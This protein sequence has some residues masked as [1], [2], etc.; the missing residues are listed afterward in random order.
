M[1]R[2]TDSQRDEPPTDESSRRT[3]LKAGS[4]TLVGGAFAFGG[5]SAVGAQD[6]G[7]G[8][9]VESQASEGVMYPEHF[10][11]NA[12]FTITSPPID[13][14]PQGAEGFL[15]SIFTDYNMRT[16]RYVRPNTQ[17]IPLFVQEEADVG[18]YSER[19]GFAVDNDFVRN[20]NVVLDGTPIQQVNAQRLT[21]VRPTIFALGRN[22]EP[23]QDSDQLVSVRFSPIPQQA[24]Q[25]V[26]DQYRQQIFGGSTPFTPV[27]QG[28]TTRGTQTT[29]GG[30]QTTTPGGTQTTPGGG[31]TTT[32]GN[33]T[34]GNQSSFDG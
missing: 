25:R 28:T 15:E 21:N 31:R 16:I 32:P 29:P 2:H 13:N 18:Q 6:G 27:Q 11:P 5:S 19:L 22:T 10:R 30:T 7:G 9:F 23:F 34:G 8:L 3:F 4:V 1:T 17:N 26:F 20:G 24:E 33:G 14:A 12:L